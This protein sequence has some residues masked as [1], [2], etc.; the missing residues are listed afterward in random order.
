MASVRR[1]LAMIAVII[2]TPVFA[3]RQPLTAAERDSL[4]KAR[5]DKE[6]ELES[7]TII[8]RK[9]M[10]PMRHGV[11]MQADIYRPKNAAGRVP[12]VFVRT[13]YNFN[14]WDVRNGAPRD[15]GAELDAV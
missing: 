10:V 15:M 14:Y 4:V 5:W 2:A 11:R 13:P 7:I 8:D 3:Q 6:R 9:L 1:G 12:I